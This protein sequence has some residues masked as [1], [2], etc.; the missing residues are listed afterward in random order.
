[1]YLNEVVAMRMAKE[2][3]AEAAHMAEQRQAAGRSRPSFRIVLGRALV[4]LGRRLA[5]PPPA[6]GTSHPASVGVFPTTLRR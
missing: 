1:M 3:I 5:G 4:R 6:A 2:R